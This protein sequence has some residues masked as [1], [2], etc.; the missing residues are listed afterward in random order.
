VLG[1]GVD[2]LVAAH[3]LARA[4]HEVIV[5]DPEAGPGPDDEQVGWVPAAVVRELD[6]AA[7][8][9]VARHPDPWAEAPLP[10]GE[11][12][13]LWC[14]P[15]RSVESIRR[16]S[17]RDAARWPAFC[18]R[19]HRIAGWLERLYT[20][21]PP[22]P[23][24]RSG[25]GLLQLGRAGLDAKRLGREGLQDLLRWLPMPVADLLDDWFESDALKG[26]LGASAVR[27][28]C[29]GPRSGGTA[30]ALLHRHAGSPP[31]VFR[32]PVSNAAKLLRARP[33]IDIRRVSVDR[34]DVEGG[35][36][37][38]VR[39]S[40]GQSLH[41]RI[42]VSGFAP[43]RTLLELADSGWLDPEFAHAVRHIR[44][45]GVSA[46]VLLEA[47][48]P[49]RFSHLVR[50]PS[51]GFLERAYDAAKYGRVSSEPWMDARDDSQTR[52]GARRI[53]VHVQY[54]PYTGAD[55]ACAEDVR[56]ALGHR[57]LEWLAQTA[58]EIE[59][60]V[61]EVL[62]PA[63]LEARH[64]W[65]QGQMQHAELALDQALWMRPLPQLARY[66][67]PITG[68]YLCGPAMHPGAGVAGAA[69]FNCAG[70]VLADA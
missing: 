57:V 58:P 14:D 17:A 3:R 24:S 1:A 50:A 45:R 26:V 68:L 52:Q 6:L 42:V 27:H 32:P 51:L 21:P 29:H 7:H 56:G 30:F 47:A 38:G 40:D 15:A 46:R 61:T 25:H 16:L 8:G 12:L 66:R 23:M 44:A 39:L 69:G 63:D 22:D 33:G 11:R 54:V 43:G 34:I 64:G 13:Q 9:F 55:G 10:G 20:A 49:R 36:V 53:E 19:L 62:L 41:A 2:E 5:L 4:G 28:L 31:G 67:T 35:R 59:A 70:V 48:G 60:K 18:G 37:G 65:P